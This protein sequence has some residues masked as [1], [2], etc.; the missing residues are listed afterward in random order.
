MCFWC[1]LGCL[2]AFPC[3][4]TR[5]GSIRLRKGNTAHQVFAFTSGTGVRNP[6]FTPQS[7]SPHTW[8]LCTLGRDHVTGPASWGTA[9]RALLKLKVISRSTQAVSTHSFEQELH[10]LNSDVSLGSL[11]AHHRAE[12]RK[13]LHAARPPVKPS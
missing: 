2:L 1:S 12:T 8:P 11:A 13:V 10:T 5:G 3:L 4:N 7:P 6:A 9:A